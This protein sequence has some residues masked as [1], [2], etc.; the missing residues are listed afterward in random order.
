MCR[1]NLAKVVPP[2]PLVHRARRVF[3]ASTDGPDHR[4]NRDQSVT[5]VNLGR[6]DRLVLSVDPVKVAYPELPVPG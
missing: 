5:S 2:A 4:E 3:P 1:E 6:S